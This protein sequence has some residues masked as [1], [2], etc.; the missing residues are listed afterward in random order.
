[1]KKWAWVAISSGLNAILMLIASF[2]LL[3]QPYVHGD[4]EVLVEYGGKIKNIFLN[5]EK[6]PS[7]KDFIFINIAYD[8]Q[9]VDKLDTNGF[10]MGKQAITDRTKL[11]KFL[12]ILGQKPKNHRFIIMDI[13]LADS[14]ATDSIHPISPDVLL[15]ESIPKNPNLLISTHLQEN[16]KPEKQIFNANYG[17]ADYITANDK[18]FKYQL[19]FNDTLKSVPL[20]MYEYLHQ[21][22]VKKGWLFNELNGQWILSIFILDFKIRNYDLFQAK[23]RYKMD[24]LE[25]ILS[26][27]MTE[28]DILNY[29]KDRII[30]IGDFETKEDTH[31]TIYGETAGPLILLNAYLALKNGDN[32]VKVSFLIFLFVAYFLVSFLVFYPQNRLKSWLEKQFPR[33]TQQI[34]IEVLSFVFLLILISLASFIFFNIHLSILYLAVYL[35]ALSWMVRRFIARAKKE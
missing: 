34:L 14:V 2:W 10:V 6:K 22:K 32:I 33:S 31:Q 12:A 24:N 15:Q 16:G 20:K 1:M 17:I 7:Q 30:V 29:V 3:T 21:T 35:Y 19:I 9:L 27:A 28:E 11:A 18:F 23:E 25:N 5:F 26:G 4:E 8:K 13:F